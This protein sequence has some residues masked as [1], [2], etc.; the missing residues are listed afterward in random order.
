MYCWFFCL[1]LLLRKWLRVFF[2]RL[3]NIIVCS[4][5]VPTYIV[6]YL[7][8]FVGMSSNFVTDVFGIVNDFFG[9]LFYCRSSPFLQ[10]SPRRAYHGK[11]LLV[12]GKAFARR[13]LEQLTSWQFWKY[14]EFPFILGWWSTTVQH[15]WWC[16]ALLPTSKISVTR[17]Q[18]FWTSLTSC[19]SYW[20]SRL[21]QKLKP[22]RT[23]SS[24]LVLYVLR[25]LG[26][27]SD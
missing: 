22:C 26:A 25:I 11:G 21:F 13:C 18:R 2:Y 24:I 5:P 23:F 15:S 16:I 19:H 9:W 4:I 14:F 3:G 12:Q 6:Q 20:K 1:L 7:T 17:L 27:A 10:G 8:I